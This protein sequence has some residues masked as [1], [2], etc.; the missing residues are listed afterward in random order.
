MI[1]SCDDL[2]CSE[3]RVPLSAVLDSM[4]D[5]V[6]ILDAK[7]H[8]LV[9]NRRAQELFARNEKALTGK[10]LQNLLPDICFFGGG[11][12]RHCDRTSEQ[13]GRYF[14]R[15]EI[16][17][18]RTCEVHLEDNN[19]RRVFELRMQRVA[20]G[21]T[22]THICVL[23]DVTERRQAEQRLQ[24]EQRK[25]GH[26]LDAMP[27]GV[28]LL[29]ESGDCHFENLASLRIWGF[30]SAQADVADRRVWCTEANGQRRLVTRLDDI[31]SARASTSV[32]HGG[33][34]IIDVFGG[35]GGV[36]SLLISERRLV[37][38]DDGYDD[39]DGNRA[40]VVQDMTEH[41]RLAKAAKLRD[42]LSSNV[43]N[44]STV[45]ICVVVTDGRIL[46]TNSK[47]SELLGYS[48]QELLRLNVRDITWADD[49]NTVCAP[50]LES[51][52]SEKRTRVA[53]EKRYRHRNGHPV[54]VVVD[55][56]LISDPA[57]ESA[58]LL[59]QIIPIDARKQAE[60]EL[61]VRDAA[62]TLAQ[63]TAHFGYWLWS[64]D[65]QVFTC[66]NEAANLLGLP[67]NTE[68]SL[69]AVAEN[70][71][72][73]DRALVDSALYCLL[74][75]EMMLDLDF[76]IV[77]PDGAV[78]RVVHMRGEMARSDSAMPLYVGTVTDITER[79]RVEDE[80]RASQRDLRQ[81]QICQEERLEDERRRIA[82]ELHDDL[83]ELLTGLKM[84]LSAIRL[85]HI[86]NPLFTSEINAVK[87]LVD[88]TFRVVRRV[89][90]NIRP[91]ALNVGLVPAVQWLGKEFASRYDIRC[92]ISI[93]L[94]ERISLP[95]EIATPVFRVIQETL[96][97]SARH[98]AASCVHVQLSF[99]D[100]QLQVDVCDDGIG[101]DPE[102]PMYNKHY[103]LFSQ[104]ERIA[105]LGGTL[106]IVSAPDK[107]TTTMFSVP[108]KDKP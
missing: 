82:L 30:A 101:F 106:R 6:L 27:A 64:P 62:L 80:L 94:D 72:G 74:H 87:R 89:A 104:R 54:W 56:S 103:G 7:A 40:V 93:G 29:D 86:E 22:G 20:L 51:L 26:I 4:P 46:M 44:S 24:R 63:R 49:W 61:A 39:G 107:G 52:V 58:Y 3:R 66:S 21:Q 78:A 45:G 81:L 84:G 99:D 15:Q 37:P 70:A 2:P 88:E 25:F 8:V 16:G 33:L 50:L 96:T 32:A 55:V 60:E 105:A 11:P 28:W 108:L 97:N 68:S 35:E 92:E 42:D 12:S 53:Y 47:L 85:R 98:A 95:D 13:C 19:T 91:P 59:G 5:V 9:A 71:H 65:E 48:E 90:S 10:H 57:A 76:R 1:F 36:K 75:G 23:R 43:F 100:D 79:K 18:C 83:G 17:H 41:L 77:T 34:E 69:W 14:E 67:G 102:A 73:E 31:C 38:G